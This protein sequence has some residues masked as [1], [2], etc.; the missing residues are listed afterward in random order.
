MTKRNLHANVRKFYIGDRQAGENKN[1]IRSVN[2]V[3]D[4]FCFNNITHTE[5]RIQK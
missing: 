1:Q 4:L 2:L 5:I 3:V